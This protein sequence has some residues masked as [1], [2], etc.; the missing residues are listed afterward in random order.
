MEHIAA[1][2]ERRMGW[3]F[4]PQKN[5][6]DTDN[7]RFEQRRGQRETRRRVANLL[8]RIRTGAKSGPKTY[9]TGLG[10]PAGDVHSLDRASC[11]LP[12]DK[13]K[14]S[15][16]LVHEHSHKPLRSNRILVCQGLWTS[17][18]VSVSDHP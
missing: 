9:H 1:T 8:P 5:E 2:K 11:A 10:A 3:A 15:E 6:S 17:T 18:E 16:N 12:T 7:F 4:L 13:R 14:D